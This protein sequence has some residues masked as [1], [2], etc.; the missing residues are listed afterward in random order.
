[1]EDYK[2]GAMETKFAELMW[3]NEPIAS[4]ELVKLCEKELSW[5]KSTTYTM[6]RRLCERNIFQNK[7]GVVSSI[8]TKQEFQA[9][10]S[11]QFVKETFGGSLPHFLA[12]FATRKKLSENEIEELQR[13]INQ[14]RR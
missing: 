12:A 9:L 4:G 8:I 7:N 2:L 1:M 13:L 10:Q 5:K 11:E 14:H 3:D 6:L